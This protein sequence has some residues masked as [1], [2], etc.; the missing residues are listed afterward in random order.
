MKTTM[1]MRDLKVKDGFPDDIDRNRLVIVQAR[2]K[3][4]SVVLYTSKKTGNP[5]YDI[6]PPMPNQ[7]EWNYI[8]RP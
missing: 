7:E 5:E 2:Q 6:I 8:I 4:N 3:C 1:K